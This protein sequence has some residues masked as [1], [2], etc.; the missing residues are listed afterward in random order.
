LDSF[1]LEQ[2]YKNQ[3]KQLKDVGH[4]SLQFNEP[5]YSEQFINVKKQILDYYNENSVRTYKDPLMTD[6]VFEY[7][8]KTMVP[9]AI[10]YFKCVPTIGYVK[11]IK[12]KTSNNSQ[13]TQFFHRDPG[14]Y[15]ILKSV[16]YLNDVDTD[17]GPLVYISK[18]NHDNLLGFSG[19]IRLSDKFVEN[20]YPDQAIELTGESGQVFFFDAKGIHKGKLP[21]KKARIAIIVNFTIHPEYGQKDN[22]SKIKFKMSKKYSGYDLLLL[23]SCMPIFG[24]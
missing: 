4:I 18:S 5:D 22:Y 13:D 10:S 17:G 23:D 1:M 9:F 8:K 7:I 2:K 3:V 21:T 11:I 15:N 20:A 6:G 19:R 24:L 16:V 12:S 14:S